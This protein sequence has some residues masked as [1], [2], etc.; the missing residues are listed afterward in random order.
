MATKAGASTKPVDK[1]KEHGKEASGL[2]HKQRLFAD[3]Y[4]ADAAFNATA[5][6]KR[7]GYSAK[8]DNVAGVE[9]HKLLK[10]PKI[11]AYIEQRMDERAKRTEIT[12]DRVL[13]EVARLAFLDIRKAFDE[14]GNL[15]PIHEIDDDTA[16]A[17]AG[18]D[19]FEEFEGR[20]EDRT[21]IG[22]TKKMKLNDKTGALTLLMRHL[23]M[24]NDKVKLQGDPENPVHVTT[25]VVV[26][27]QKVP[28]IVQTKP[29]K[30]DGRD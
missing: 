17:L 1:S 16:A 19:I 20:G 18:L 12:Q 13:K 28:A 6:Y 5:A 24:L 14:H 26:V 21:F 30:S 22:L 7:A 8:S 11:A 15:K 27:P 23:G 10:N 29:M 9:A 25:K 3:E 4:L 2:T